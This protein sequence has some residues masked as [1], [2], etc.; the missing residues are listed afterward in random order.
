[1]QLRTSRSLR[2]ESEAAADENAQYTLVVIEQFEDTANDA[3]GMQGAAPQF[4]IS[5]IRCSMSLSEKGFL[6]KA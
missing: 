4:K 5:L 2:P 1:M 6:R 3:I